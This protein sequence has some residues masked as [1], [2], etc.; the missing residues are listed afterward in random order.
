MGRDRVHGH[1]NLL[2][3]HTEKH[4]TEFKGYVLYVEGRGT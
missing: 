2:G 4:I 1:E 3:G